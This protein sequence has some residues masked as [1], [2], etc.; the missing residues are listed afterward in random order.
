MGKI[1]Q[2]LT[3]IAPNALARRS[4]KTQVPDLNDGPRFVRGFANRFI[5]SGHEKAMLLAR[6]PGNPQ[7]QPQQRMLTRWSS[8]RQKTL[9]SPNRPNLNR[10]NHARAGCPSN[11]RAD[12]LKIVGIQRE[13][14]RS[15]PDKLSIQTNN[16][17][18]SIMNPDQIGQ[19]QIEAYRKM[20]GQ[21]RLR[22]G[23]GLYE[24][25]LEMARQA[26]R[27]QYPNADQSEI[28]QRLRARVHAGYAIENSGTPCS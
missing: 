4:G 7:P 11:P 3:E 13:L 16:L 10:L 28:E 21:Q 12:I 5:V 17:F 24:A 18:R 22:I 19:Q 26:I 27:N 2:K 25:S 20:T 15:D 8:K 9:V 23:L 1:D 14:S 6:H